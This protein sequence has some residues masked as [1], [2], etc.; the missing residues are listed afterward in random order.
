MTLL[1]RFEST[2][3]NHKLIS[4][5]TNLLI[6]LSGGPDSVALLHLAKRSSLLR[7]WRVTLFACYINHGMREEAD[8]EQRVV[9]AL[10]GRLGVF[11]VVRRLGLGCVS[12]AAARSYRLANLAQTASRLGCSTIAT[13]HT[14]D[15]QAETLLIRLLRG[16]PPNPI[17]LITRIHGLNFIHPLLKIRKQ[18]LL[19]SLNRSGVGYILDTTNY[20]GRNL[21]ARIRRN[22]LPALSSMWGNFV[23]ACGGLAD[24]SGTPPTPFLKT[25]NFFGL[26]EIHIEATDLY[27]GAGHRILSAATAA[28]SSPPPDRHHFAQILALPKTGGCVDIHNR[29]RCVFEN[30]CFV[31]WRQENAEDF[32]VRLPVPG[33]A[34]IPGATVRAERISQLKLNDFITSKTPFVEAIPSNID[35]L[36]LR[37]AKPDDRFTPLGRDGTVMVREFLKKVGIPA[38][39]RKFVVILEADGRVVWVVG[40]RLDRSFA[41]KDGPA[42]LVEVRTDV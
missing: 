15:D 20:V 34:T 2:I 1:R 7:K 16:S 19:A 28:L 21:R 8:R 35:E 18:E 22:L 39:R 25:V 32:A 23:S 13:A 38:R 42:L 9:E 6:A 37:R 12:E 3:K 4:P 10:C 31:L 33:S 26:K 17:P 27:S 24:V 41:I 29:I 36:L 5:N 14:S 40:V 11:L 30:G